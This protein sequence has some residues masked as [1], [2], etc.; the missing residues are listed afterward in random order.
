MK[1]GDGR[2]KFFYQANPSLN[3]KRK[4]GES[5]TLKKRQRPRRHGRR[6]W[7]RGEGKEDGFFRSKKKGGSVTLTE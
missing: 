3:G 1:K 7:E 6:A 5:E 2:S 4:G